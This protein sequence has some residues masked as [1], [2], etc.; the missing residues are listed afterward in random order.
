[1][2][3]T[4]LI[5]SIAA[6]C[7]FASC[8]NDPSAPANDNSVVNGVIIDEQSNPVPE[9]IVEA[10]SSTGGSVIDIDTTDET[11]TFLFKKIT[12]DNTND[13]SLRIRHDDFKDNSFSLNELIKNRTEK[14]CK[15]PVVHYD[16]CCGKLKIYVKKNSDSTPLANTEIRLTRENRTIRFVRTND[17]GFVILENICPG[18]YWLR[19]SRTG[20]NVIEK[21]YVTENCD[22]TARYYYMTASEGSSDTCCNGMINVYPRDSVDITMLTGAIVKIWKD[23]VLFATKTVEQNGVTLKIYVQ[24]AMDSMCTATTIPTANL[25]LN[26]PAMILLITLNTLKR[27]IVVMAFLF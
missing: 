2:K 24:V 3:R 1:M 23:G 17:E 20:Y 12:A 15:I 13:I 9:A 16:T 10:F 5:V 22:S 21:D 4:I 27:M 8:K 18:R 19:F 7:L 25:S 6:L 14:G 26:S 11:G